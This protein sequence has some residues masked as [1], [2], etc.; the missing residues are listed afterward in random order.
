MFAYK[1]SHKRV[2][3]RFANSIQGELTND[4]FNFPK[5]NTKTF[6][7]KIRLMKKKKKL[8]KERSFTMENVIKWN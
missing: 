2:L 6:L 4:D 3:I 8:K 5:S 7:S 1:I